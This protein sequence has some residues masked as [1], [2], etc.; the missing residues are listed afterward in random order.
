MNLD[1]EEYLPYLDDLDLSQEK[2]I[3]IIKTVYGLM[4]SQVD[5]AFGT[6]PVQLA[7]KEQEESSW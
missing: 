4:Q 6:H 3:E 7:L 1:V 2:K 5:A